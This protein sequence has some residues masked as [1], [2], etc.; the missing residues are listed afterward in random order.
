MNSI[1]YSGAAIDGTVVAFAK[2]EVLSLVQSPPAKPLSSQIAHERSRMQI[3][4]DRLDL[5]S[6]AD[7]SHPS[8]AKPPM[9][10]LMQRRMP[11]LSSSLRV[12]LLFRLLRRK[13]LRQR[14]R[15]CIGVEGIFDHG[16]DQ[17]WML[18]RRRQTPE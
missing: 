2:A 16:I 18:L 6:L 10:S 4:F 9:P 5:A 3:V 14:G 1:G 11:G 15:E 7:T 17:N 13:L 8:P 12:D